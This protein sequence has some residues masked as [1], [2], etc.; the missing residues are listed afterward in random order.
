[1]C[2]YPVKNN[3][4]VALNKPLVDGPLSEGFSNL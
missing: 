2:M 4:L 1:M 3:P